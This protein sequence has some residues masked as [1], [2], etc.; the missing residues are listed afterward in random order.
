MSLTGFVAVESFVGCPCPHVLVCTATRGRRARRIDN[1]S[2][3]CGTVLLAG[4]IMAEGYPYRYISATRFPNIVYYK[5]ENV[6][7]N[8]ETGKVS[9]VQI[10]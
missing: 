2:V 8:G 9:E 7:K 3:I 5:Y 10:E 6:I 1:F 4:L